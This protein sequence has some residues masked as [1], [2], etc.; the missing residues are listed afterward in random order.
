MADRLDSAEPSPLPL[1]SWDELR[2]WLES[3]WLRSWLPSEAAL[4]PRL[5]LGARF[6]LMLGE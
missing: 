1:C 4:V 6:R 5:K 2:S 3:D